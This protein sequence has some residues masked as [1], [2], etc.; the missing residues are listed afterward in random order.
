M[1]PVLALKTR[2]VTPSIGSPPLVTR[3]APRTP[4]TGASIAL[5][6][7]IIIANKGM[8]QQGHVRVVAN[9]P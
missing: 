1:V 6:D 4:H 7:A 5:E 3:I 9:P 8:P 2:I